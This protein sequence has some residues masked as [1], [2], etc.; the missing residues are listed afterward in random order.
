MKIRPEIIAHRGRGPWRC[1]ENSIEAM[2]AAWSAGVRWV[3]CDVWASS[4]RVPVVIHDETLDRTTDQSGAVE[5]RTWNEL[6]SARLRDCDGNVAEARLPSLELLL[7]RMPAE[8]A[9]MIEIK[10]ADDRELVRR[11]VAMLGPYPGRWAIQSFDERNL[12][13]AR[14][15]GLGAELGLLVESA[16]ELAAAMNSPW[17]AVRMNRKISDAAVVETLKVRGKLVGVWTVNE[18]SEMERLARL[19]LDQIITDEPIAGMKV[20]A[21]LG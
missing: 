1:P 6:S 12:L 20:M 17:A 2:M 13:H 9:V 8:G 7:A 14:E 3:E 11:V 10:P 18:A 16:E 5:G 21:A 15:L 19:G 4:D